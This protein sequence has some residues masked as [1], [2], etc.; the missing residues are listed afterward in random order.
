MGR[1]RA[2]ESVRGLAAVSVVVYHA[3]A[4]GPGDSSSLAGAFLSRL[5][6]GVPV[7]F[8]I[9]GYVLYRPFAA[10]TFDGRPWPGMRRYATNR[11]ARIVP[12]YWVALTVVLLATGVGGGLPSY[13]FLQNVTP[14][15]AR[16]VIDVAWT[17]VSEV[18]FYVA[19][20]FIAYGLH[21]LRRRWLVR[22]ALVGLVVAGC[23]ARA[24]VYGAGWSI[25]D[26]TLRETIDMFAAGM[27]AAT[28]SPRRV[29][30]VGLAALAV[31]YPMLPAFGGASRLGD[32]W[33]DSL[34]I[35]LSAL[36]FAIVVM[37]LPFARRLEVRPLLYLGTISYGVYLWHHP[38]MAAAKSE[39]HVTGFAAL[40]AIA[41]PAAVL[42]GSL[43]WWLVEKPSLAAVKR[44][45]ARSRVPAVPV[46]D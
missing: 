31:I 30:L 38:I 21:L 40:L 24:S 6:L 5:W 7:F 14:P 9:S 36:A 10:A 11:V 18:M 1:V 41:V 35:T 33:S 27:L 34:A 13:L 42:T 8:V 16:I 4:T 17:L 15:N 25:H 12:A 46:P 32:N 2:I 39:L 29:A 26:A 22:V 3:W 37:G 23:A 45:G 20:P 28:F 44:R 43:S 19:L